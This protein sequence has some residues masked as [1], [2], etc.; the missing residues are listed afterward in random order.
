MQN[1]KVILSI[2]MKIDFNIVSVYISTLY[3]TVVITFVLLTPYKPTVLFSK[4]VNFA[5]KT[6][7]P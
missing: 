1:H 2:G 7:R 4:K 5:L 6:K 3:K